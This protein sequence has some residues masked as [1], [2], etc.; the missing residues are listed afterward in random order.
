[1]NDWMLIGGMALLTFMPRYLPLG[2][3]GRVH[4][5]PWLQRALTFVPVAVLTAIVAQTALYR[6][7]ALDL[8]W[9]NHRA[10]AALCAAVAAHFSKSMF[11]T[12]IVGLAT[13]ALLGFLA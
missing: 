2:L 1:M 9:H 10:T 5:A 7:G 11:V 3:A 4:I 8:T 12:V 6:H 13:F